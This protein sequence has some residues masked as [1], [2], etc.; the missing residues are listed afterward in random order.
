[1]DLNIKEMDFEELKSLY[2][3][4]GNEIKSR[5]SIAAPV[6]FC[7]THECHESSTHHL[8]KYKHWAKIV[9]DVDIT[10]TNGYAFIGDFISV[11]QE[12]MIPE[13]SVIV[14]VCG[15]DFKVYKIINGS[16]I[17]YS[18]GSYGKLHDFIID[19]NNLIKK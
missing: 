16:K 15:T 9:K 4:I 17:Y 2:A 6:L 12:H 14:E 13:G 11:N 8:S 10:K 7:Y 19:V 1:M 18:R 5:E 3:E